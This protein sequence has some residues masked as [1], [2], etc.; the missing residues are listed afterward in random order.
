M[1]TE[2]EYSSK[3]DETRKLQN[4]N[5]N[6]L[7]IDKIQDEEY[8]KMKNFLLNEN[9]IYLYK[10][11]S[12]IKYKMNMDENL[13]YISIT[14]ENTKIDCINID[15]ISKITK[16]NINQAFFSKGLFSRKI[17][18]SNCFSIYCVNDL[19]EEKVFNIECLNE[20]ITSKYLK[21][22]NI[23]IDFDKSFNTIK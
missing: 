21:Y 6:I 10:N 20:E 2:K 18:S 14:N 7:L 5:R 23:L 3:N 17:K 1:K 4:N 16:D 22:F 15:S 19:K 9:I 12:C 11:K 13:R 8:D